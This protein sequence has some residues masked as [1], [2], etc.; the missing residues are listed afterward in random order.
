[1]RSSLV[2]VW[3]VGF[4]LVSL[5]TS[6][7]AGSLSDLLESPL[8][9]RLELAQI[10]PALATTVASSYPVASASSSVTYVYNPALETFERE[11]RVAGPIIGERAET[12]G[13]GAFNFAASYSYVHLTTINGDDL[14]QLVNRVT[15]GGRLIV[16]PVKG[17]TKLKDGR[18]TNFLP[19]RVVADLDVEAHIFAP[20]LTY[21]VTPDF[22]VNLT[23]PLV[24]TALDVTADT[25]VPDPR[26]P[27]F[28]VPAGPTRG[29]RS[30]SDSAFGV[31]DILLRAKYILRR[32][33]PFDVAAGLGL[34]LPSGDE[35]NFQGSGTTR[36][37]PTLIF[38]RIF[39][40][41][42]QPLVN[43]GMDLNADD[44]GRSVFRWAV[45]GTA[46]LVGPLTGALVFLG[47]DELGAQADKIQRPF[48]FQI[49][50]NDIFDASIGVRWRFTDSGVVALNTLV[51]LNNDGLRPD[52]IP[53]FEVEYAF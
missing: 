33:R 43:I 8:F 34:S 44:A 14:D 12:I 10:A 20:S 26:L 16:F 21:G 19:V 46:T 13:K 4:T 25:E 24:R 6:A 35:K 31:G 30:L 22:D 3:L 23:V 32:E 52:V 37:Q 50:R 17:G 27:Q 36:V 41:R 45:G 29:S 18:F 5:D 7:R 39:A 53:T 1:M 42:F 9:R 38:S 48:F 15:V 51:P 28:A 2:T 40:D 47:R 11:T 49:E